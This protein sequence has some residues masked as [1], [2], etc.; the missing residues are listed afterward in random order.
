MGTLFF[1]ATPTPRSIAADAPGN[2]KSAG[3]SVFSL[4]QEVGSGEGKEKDSLKVK[5]RS[6][7]V[8]EN[9]ALHFL[10]GGQS[11]NVVDRKGVTLIKRECC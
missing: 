3:K 5:E 7:N 4:R 1:P 11:G 8:I 10:E 2:R 6:R 9:K